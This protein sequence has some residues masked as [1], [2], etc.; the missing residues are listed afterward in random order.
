MIL[1]NAGIKRIHV[2]HCPQCNSIE[3]R[4]C[5]F[6]GDA[7]GYF[8]RN[9]CQHCGAAVY[10]HIEEYDWKLLDTVDGNERP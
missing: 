6:Y 3:I 5:T 1:T 2:I 7:Y 8:T 10:D 4:E 9:V